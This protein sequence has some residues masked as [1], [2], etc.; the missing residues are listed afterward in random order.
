[1][2]SKKRSGRSTDHIRNKTVVAARLINNT[3]RLVRID[4][5]FLH[6]KAFDGSCFVFK[7]DVI[8]SRL[9]EGF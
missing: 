5:A 4:E 3:S 9:S 8:S 6:M 2:F 7:R 1:M